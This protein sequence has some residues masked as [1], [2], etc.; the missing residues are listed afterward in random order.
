MV[1]S[2]KFSAP[3]VA[4]SLTIA[5]VPAV[6][7]NAVPT[8]AFLEITAPAIASVSVV[9]VARVM[10]FW[11]VPSFVRQKATVLLPKAVVTMP[12]SAVTSTC[13]LTVKRG[14]VP[15]VLFAVRFF[16]V[17]VVMPPYVMGM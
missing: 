6:R 5:D 12:K 3:A 11:V 14:T 2:W 4:D 8:P 16:V 17:V 1:K 15:V 9:P 10:A 13:P 7:A